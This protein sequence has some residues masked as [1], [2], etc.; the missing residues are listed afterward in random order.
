MASGTTLRSFYGPVGLHERF[1]HATRCRIGT[2]RLIDLRLIGLWSG[3]LAH[4]QGAAIDAVDRAHPS[5]AARWRSSTS[6]VR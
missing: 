1:L 3:G 5:S 2:E 4:M 6:E